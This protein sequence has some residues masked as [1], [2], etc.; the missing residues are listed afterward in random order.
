MIN[1]AL[2]NSPAHLFTAIHES[3]NMNEM[4]PMKISI[5][6]NPCTVDNLIKAEIC[7]NKIAAMYTKTGI[8]ISPDLLRNRGTVKS[9]IKNVGPNRN[10]T[11]GLNV[12]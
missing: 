7:I 3:E 5:D 2:V 10:N 9:K 11:H 6:A 8:F 4:D 1:R 12:A